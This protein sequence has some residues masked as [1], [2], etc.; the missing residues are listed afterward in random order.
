[1]LK[2]IRNYFLIVSALFAFNCMTKKQ[3]IIPPELMLKYSDVIYKSESPEDPNSYVVYI[4]SEH[5]SGGC[6][7]S[8]SEKGYYLM[9]KRRKEVYKNILFTLEELKRKYDLDL[10][11]LES[12]ELGDS[13]LEGKSR[14]PSDIPEKKLDSI[15]R[16]TNHLLG[17]MIKET[18]GDKIFTFGV[19]DTTLGKRHLKINKEISGIER[20]FY[21]RDMMVYGKRGYLIWNKNVKK[22]FLDRSA[23]FLR[24]E[25]QHAKSKMKKVIKEREKSSITALLKEMEERGKK[26]AAFVMGAAHEENIKKILRKKGIPFYVLQPKGYRYET[27]KSK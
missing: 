5:I 25:Y 17:F 19:S 23:W 26:R 8:F 15:L 7:S 22:E 6:E 18:F 14:Y 13:S 2:N 4:K 12:L 16:G 20:E 21:G 3:E 11:G 1:M 24:V 10:V 27:S 9:E